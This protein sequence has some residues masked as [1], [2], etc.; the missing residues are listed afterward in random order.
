MDLDWNNSGGGVLFAIYGS[1]SSRLECWRCDG[2]GGGV[3]AY[4]LLYMARDLDGN[5]GVFL[6]AIVCCGYTRDLDRKK[7]I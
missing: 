4:S 1:R 2:G 3:L 6:L 5:G 7:G